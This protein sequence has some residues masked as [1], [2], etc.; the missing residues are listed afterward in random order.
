MKKLLFTL[1]LTCMVGV[2]HA[3]RELFPIN[4]DNMEKIAKAQS[5]SVRALAVRLSADTLDRSLTWEERRLAVYGMGILNPQLNLKK[6]AYDGNEYYREGKYE[7]ALECAKTLLK[8]NPLNTNALSLAERSIL[9]MVKAGNKK[10]TKSNAE[11]YYLRAQRVYNT[12]ATT[13]NGSEDYP[14]HVTEVPEE[15]NFMR[16]YLE[17][18]EYSGQKLVGTCDVITLSE[19]SQYYNAE[20]VWFDATWPLTVLQREFEK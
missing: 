7:E 19:T 5:D 8:D 2:C 17:I 10:Y 11:I 20:T 1:L 9:Q 15:Y 6:A 16:Y 13:G 18:W 14:F 12:I 4:W 3:E